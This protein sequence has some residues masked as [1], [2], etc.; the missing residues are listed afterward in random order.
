MQVLLLIL[1]AAVLLPV[2]GRGDVDSWSAVS[3]VVGGTAMLL[4]AAFIRSV[5]LQRRLAGPD[6]PR[7]IKRAARTQR[8]VQWSAVLIV[9]GGVIGLGFQAS[10]RSLVGDPPLLDEVLVMAPAL[11]SI[12]AAWWIFQ[13]FERRAGEATFLRRIDEGQPVHPLPSRTA[14]VAL[15]VRS[16]ML[17]I[18]A[19]IGLLAFTGE[20]VRLLVSMVDSVPAWAE[21]MLPIAAVLPV[22]AVA[23]WLVVRLAGATPLPPGEVRDILEGMCHRAGVRVR[24]LLLWPTGG[25][26]IN[27]GVTGIMGALRWVMLTDG[28]L[29]LLHRHQV[30]AVM[31]HELAHARRHHMIWM[32]LSVVALAIGMGLLMD[33]LVVSLYQ[34]RIDAG[35]SVAAMQ[36]DLGFLDLTATGLVLA[37]V[38]MGFGWVSRRFERQADAFA[39]VRMSV[40]EQD[41]A[42]PVVSSAGAV[43]MASALLVVSHANGVP[44]ER[45]SWR[46]GSIASR[47]RHLESLI[48]RPVDALPIDRT[49]RLLN[50]VS[51]SIIGLAAAWWG[52]ELATEAGDGIGLNDTVAA[53]VRS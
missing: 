8:M 33:P 30:M 25:L 14:W 3:V 11:F 51:M 24:D 19:P 13:P 17:V 27:A 7:W 52:I 16:Q 31:A 42:L 46:H 40:D 44:M 45:F 5:V 32:G 29:D 48:G 38:L 50:L 10:V 39:A 9:V 41:Q 35:G 47:R 37:G 22:V 36:R 2:D 1:V 6:G 4:L 43:S 53:E 21:T 26:I 49:V 12:V 23:P 18:L 28:L 20:S 15:Q 34:W